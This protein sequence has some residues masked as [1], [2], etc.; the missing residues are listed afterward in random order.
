MLFQ[1]NKVNSSGG[2]VVNKIHCQLTSLIVWLSENP[3][4]V[5][6]VVMV[7]SLATILLA[8]AVGL[9]PDGIMVAGPNGGVG[10][11]GAT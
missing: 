8:L 6:F 3:N 2:K 11:G 4:H 7:V 10:G 5:R 9:S 1:R